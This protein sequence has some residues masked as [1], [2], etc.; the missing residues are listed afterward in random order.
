M[1]YTNR[2][3]YSENVWA[4]LAPLPR[5]PFGPVTIHAPTGAELS[6]SEQAATIL[7][8]MGRRD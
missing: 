4:V 1:S 5:G 7:D 2:R 3:R 8:V 6:E